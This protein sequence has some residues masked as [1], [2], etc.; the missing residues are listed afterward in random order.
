MILRF[1]NIHTR[2]LFK[3][4][5]TQYKTVEKQIYVTFTNL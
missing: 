4:P 1:N 2:A 3:Q 5:T